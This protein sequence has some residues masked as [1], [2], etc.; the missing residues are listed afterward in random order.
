ML[1]EGDA[2]EQW[3]AYVMKVG[4]AH[5][6]ESLFAASAVFYLTEG[7]VYVSISL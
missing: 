4:K 7:V 6:A 5:Y 3:N 1:L 2:F